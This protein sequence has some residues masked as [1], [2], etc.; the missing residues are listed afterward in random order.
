[1]ILDKKYKGSNE[2]A[3][4]GI[5]IEIG[6]VPSTILAETIGIE[7]DD[8]YNLIKTD[9]GQRT[10][11]KGIYAAGDITTNSDRF[12]QVVTAVSEG[13]IAANSVYTDSKTKK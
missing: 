12:M 1:M 6:S 11:I 9:A 13:A 3:L 8:Y 2:L 5:F 10:N 4:D 7:L